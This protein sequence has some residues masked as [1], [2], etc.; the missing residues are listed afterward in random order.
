MKLFLH[1]TRASHCKKGLKM[2]TELQINESMGCEWVRRR[3][4]GVRLYRDSPHK[5]TMNFVHYLC[6]AL[7]L[8]CISIFF[9]VTVERPYLEPTSSLNTYLPTFQLRTG[10]GSDP[11]WYWPDPDQT[12]LSWKCSIYFMMTFKKKFLPFII[13]RSLVIIFKF[14]SNK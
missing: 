13:W 10:R 1:I 9:Q 2:R 11:V 8:I 7:I 6:I 3:S 14:S 5:K 4:C 12:P